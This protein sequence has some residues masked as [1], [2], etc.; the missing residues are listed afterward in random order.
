VNPRPVSIGPKN[1][2][3]MTG[4]SW[5][6]LRDHASELGVAIV[7]VD[8]KSVILADELLA[9]LEKRRPAPVEAPVDELEAMRERVRRAG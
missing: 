9:A 7:K 2:E 5:R 3:A 8:G 6:W 4:H 1:A